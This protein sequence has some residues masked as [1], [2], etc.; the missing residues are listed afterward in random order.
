[1]RVS[2][3]TRLADRQVVRQAL[4]NLLDNAIK[5]SSPGGR[6][7]VSVGDN[8]KVVTIDVSDTG[9]GIPEDARDLVFDRF[10]QSTA[11]GG[12]VT[13]TGLGLSLAKGAVE[14]TG[15]TL[16][17][18]RSSPEGSMFRISLPRALPQASPQSLP[19]RE[20]S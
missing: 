9:P 8:G 10:Y 16:S 11:T 13:G 3:R 7:G 1:M 2:R 15:G 4:I 12:G 18:E 17:L 19:Q 6:I 20:A 14:A 5:F